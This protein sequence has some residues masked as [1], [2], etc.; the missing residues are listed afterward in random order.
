[1]GHRLI[2]QESDGRSAVALQRAG[3]LMPEMAGT[4][5]AFDCPLN[6]QQREDLRW[7]LEDY[8]IA[9]F[10]VY[11]ERG[12]A[13]Q[14]QLKPWG[15]ALFDAV[16]GSGKPGRDAY[17]RAYEAGPPDLVLSSN[18]PKFLSLPW[19]LLKDP[20]R[21]DPL[22]LTLASAD[23][24]LISVVAA[25]DTADRVPGE[26]LRVLMVIA[27]PAGLH[28]VG[29]QMIA[30]PLLRRLEAVSGRVQ[31]DVLRPP[32]LEALES[33]LAEAQ[34]EGRPYQILHFDGHGTFG[35]AAGARGASQHVYDAGAAQGYVL[36]E[37]A[38]GGERPVSAAQFALAVNKAK[39]PLV[40]LNAC[41]S[42]TLG[43]AAAEAAVATRLLEGGAASVVAMG[44][45]IYAVAAAEF[46][47]AFYDALFAGETTSTAV[48]A[49][50]QRLFSRNERPSPKGPLPLDDWIV[51]VHYTRRALAFPELKRTRDPGQPSL[52]AMLDRLGQRPPP[53]APAGVPAEGALDP[54]GRFVGRDAAFY[55]LELALRLQRVVVVHG[56]GGTG[57]TELAKAFARW[58]RATGGLDDPDWVLFHSFEPGVASFGL[59]GVITA[60]GLKLFGPDFI[61]RTRGP[62]QRR[63]VVREA[64]KQHRMLLI[65]D[66][67]ESVSSMP[68]PS[69]A[70][71]PLGE[72]QQEQVRAFL[73]DL[74]HAGKSGVII[75]SRSPEPWLGRVRRLELSG[76]TVAEAAEMADD[77]LAPYPRAQARRQE[78]AYAELLEWLN[79]HPL[80][81]RLV[82]P[83]LERMGPADLLAAL[84]GEARA[85]PPGFEAGESRLAS[86]GASVK[87]SFDHLPAVLRERLPALALFEGMADADVLAAMSDVEGVPA[88][89]ASVSKADWSATLA[90]LA[91]IG[92]VTPLG[93]GMYSL[94][95]ALP[96]YLAAEWRQ[97][98]GEG[99]DIEWGAAQ[100]ALLT[101]YAAF[102]D[103]LRQQVQSGFAEVALAL[104][105]QQRRTMGRLL[106][107]ALVARRYKEAQ[108][109]LQPL[110]VFWEVRGFPQEAQ[111][112]TERCRTALEAA[113]GTPPD[114]ETRAGALWLFIVGAEANRA[115]DAGDLARAEASYGAMRRLLEAAPPSVIRSRRLAAIY[116]QLGNVAQQRRDLVGAGAWHLKALEIREELG[117]Q[118]DLASSYH[119]LGMIAHQQGDLN[120]ATLWSEKALEIREELGNQRDLASIY[121][122]LGIVAQKRDDLASAE[123]WYR[124]TLA[125][126]KE[127]D[128][129]PV[130]IK[131]Y[132]QLGRISQLRDELAEAEAWYR[133]TLVIAQELDDRPG[134]ASTYGQLGLLS[135]QRGD[136]QAALDWFV[137]CIA[138]FEEF[139]HPATGPGPRHLARL[140][141]KLGVPALEASWRKCTDSNLPLAIRS[142]I[143]QMITKE[144]PER[145]DSG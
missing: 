64:L 45:S 12:Q 127:L 42:G 114:L 37:G 102:G 134:L 133:N 19:E 103:G 30:R 98:A 14:A 18:A 32:T 85:L 21:A 77:L 43:Q 138:L 91:S 51:P 80:S 17:L 108:K 130:L 69:G 92:L 36:F 122:Q 7:Y 116:H 93:G 55:E 56:P 52:D 29:Y 16:F 10:A 27:R 132:H 28:D 123:A 76:L 39:V 139:P 24:T 44:Y 131:T 100:G 101:G 83:A 135:E 84:R 121:H 20:E 59:D 86:L 70:T 90:A 124:K 115:A 62:E 96:A 106:Q 4:P 49:G 107:L 15:E 38:S 88:R 6:S 8:L 95:P 82:L 66:N 74:V 33:R 35:S 81:L 129:R 71:P 144:G 46:M 112:W 110:N 141:V 143:E 67:F 72:A 1:M 50:R 3:Q 99:F 5:I 40:V 140:T 120:R 57:K 75:T 58:W 89:F 79:G 11:E 63:E 48:V 23:R 41:R 136:N 118:R 94:H 60:I 73:A 104:I 34:E 61:G 87:Y 117:N 145:L 9:P 54:V 109:I 13:I 128:D 126:A 111:A 125:I 113:D 22:A 97:L 25:A 137:R 53:A 68:D 142:G 78:R 65:W 119:Q 31:L 47:A 105:G 2:V 26:V